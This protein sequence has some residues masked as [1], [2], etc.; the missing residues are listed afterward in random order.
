M[1]GYKVLTKQGL[2]GPFKKSSIYKAVTS[3]ML[4][5]QARLL[6]IDTGRYISAAE[7]V[8]EKVEPKARPSHKVD[9]DTRPHDPGQTTKA[10]PLKLAEDVGEPEPARPEPGQPLPKVVFAGRVP[11]K[12]A[13]KLPPSLKAKPK[14]P[15][16]RLPV[17]EDSDELVLTP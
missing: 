10:E 16:P 2:K 6:E 5:L 12:K 1:T 17:G 13:I 4:P 11:L 7:L 3:A 14:L 15:K 8:G 9:D